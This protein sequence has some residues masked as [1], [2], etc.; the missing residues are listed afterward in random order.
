MNERR[1]RLRIPGHEEWLGYD[2]D[3][4]VRYAHKLFFGKSVEDVQRY[5][6]DVRSIERADELL[7]MPRRAFQYYVRAF[8]TFV[9]SDAA[10]GDCDSA[11][12]FLGLLAHREEHDPG[13]VAQVFDV[14]EE[15]VEYVASNQALFDADPA[16]YGD[17]RERAD[18][19]LRAVGRPASPA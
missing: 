1:R 11:S 6:G 14:L 10:R 4:D 18:E 8:A 9:M 16:I 2:A 5:F 19:V 3:L 12:S 7:F 17:F 13:S 15:A